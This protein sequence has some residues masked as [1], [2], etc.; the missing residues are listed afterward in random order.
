[1]HITHDTRRG[2]DDVDTAR[3]ELRKPGD[4][5]NQPGQGA[6]KRQLLADAHKDQTGSLRRQRPARSL[7][8]L[9]E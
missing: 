2:Q 8:E 5:D 9:D 7:L 3:G 1:M 6:D 4:R